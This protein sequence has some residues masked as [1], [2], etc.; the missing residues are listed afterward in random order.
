MKTQIYY[1]SGTGNSLH[2]ARQLKKRV[3]G[4]TLVSMVA[5]ERSGLLKA[6]AERVG[7]VFPIHCLCVP[8]FVRAFLEK[9]DLSGATYLFAV[10]SRE[11]SVKVFSRVDRV[12]SKQERRLDASFAVQM[13]ETYLPVFEVDTDEE[14]RRK[15]AAMLGEMDFIAS[16]VNGRKR[17]RKPDP[18]EFGM[19]LYYIMR[20]VMIFLYNRTRYFNLENRF[21]ADANCTGCG[22][23]NDICLSGRI[24]MSGDKPVWDKQTG[25]LFCF[26]CIHY[27]PAQAIQIRR[28]K[29]AARGRYHHPEV[30]AG[31]L[32]HSG[33]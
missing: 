6:E 13:P 2:I 33:G 12:L 28:S 24:R 31:D 5:A 29:S 4:S 11:C 20:P 17:Y 1:F 26:A 10:T 19:Y 15:E 8:L 9:I 3:P 21:H 27:C 14:I 18:K 25:C 23:C 7:F 30:S 32:I 22:L 16:V